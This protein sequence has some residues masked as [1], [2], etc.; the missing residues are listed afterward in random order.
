M[1]KKVLLIIIMLIIGRLGYCQ[2]NIPD[3]SLFTLILSEYVKDGLVD[4]KNL[5]DDKHF[6]EYLDQLSKTNINDFKNIDD[7]IAFWINVYNAYTLK[8][9]LEEYPVE[10][11][12]DLHWGGLYLGSVLGTTIW[13]DDK[14]VINNVKLSLNNIEH[15]TLRKA[16]GDERVHFALVCASISCPQLRNEAYEGSSVNEQLEEEA[17]TFFSDRSKN[18]FDP[19]TKTAHLSKILDWYDDDFGNSKQEILEYVARYLPD[20]LASEII[21]YIDEWKIEYLDYNWNLNDYIQKQHK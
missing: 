18:R 4:Y 5:K 19:E 9:I 10:S 20:D 17:R 13:D 21:A 16:I 11:I 7:I 12:N 6:D 14:I 1:I 2:N 15:D 3:N 8:F